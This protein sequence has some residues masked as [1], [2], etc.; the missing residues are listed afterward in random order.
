MTVCGLL[1]IGF[2]RVLEPINEELLV[3]LQ[4]QELTQHDMG[5]RE[6]ARQGQVTVKY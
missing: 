3:L 4:H 1:S 2:G 5:L 6:K